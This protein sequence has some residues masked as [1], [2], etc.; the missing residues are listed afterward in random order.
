M[1]KKSSINDGMLPGQK[2]F[3]FSSA[4]L[5]HQGPDTVKHESLWSRFVQTKQH[6]NKTLCNK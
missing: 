4:V 6:E 5:S 2:N 3:L 1:W